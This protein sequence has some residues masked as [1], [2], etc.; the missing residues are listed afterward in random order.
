MAKHWT[1][2][3]VK[4][5]L[6]ATI[7][8]ERAAHVARL[9]IQTVTARLMGVASRQVLAYSPAGSHRDFSQLAGA[10]WQV[11]P[12]CEGDL[13]ARMKHYFTSAFAAGAQRVV[14]LGADS[15]NVPL[16]YINT[17]FERLATQQLVLGPTGDGGYY[18]I[19]A[20]RTADAPSIPPVFDEMPWSSERLW[21]AT[22][23]RLAKQQWREGYEWSPLPLWYDIDTMDDL[24]RLLRDLSSD[25]CDPALADLNHQLQAV[26]AT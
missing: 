20:R 14:L 25:D 22:T 6:A 17:A 9:F 23:S 5:R 7:G 4:T 1:P 26:L 12:Q 21:Q 24:N 13:G 10:N 15:P 8:D 18:L 11:E 2:G 19:G 3:Q 16:A